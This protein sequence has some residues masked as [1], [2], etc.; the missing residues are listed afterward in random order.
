[1]LGIRPDRLQRRAP[2]HGVAP[3]QHPGKVAIVGR[4][5]RSVV[6]RAEHGQVVVGK[7]VRRRRR[8]HRDVRAADEV[9]APDPGT[10]RQSLAPTAR[11]T[12]SSSSI[13]PTRS[14][15]VAAMPG[16]QRL[17]LAAPAF[18]EQ[19]DPAGERPPEAR[20]RSRRVLSVQ[21]LQMTVMCDVEHGRRER[22]SCT[23]R[24]QSLEQGRPVV[25][26]NRTSSR[27]RPAM[28]ESSSV[29]PRYRGPMAS[30]LAQTACRDEG[31]CKSL[32]LLSA[33]VTGMWLSLG[34]LALLLSGACRQG[35]PVVDLGPKPPQRARHHYWH[36][37]RPRRHVA[38]RRPHSG[39][40]RD[41][42]PAQR[43]SVQTSANGGFTIQVP[44][45][46]YRIEL[47][48]Q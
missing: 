6:N 36:R 26:G 20:A 30:F 38:S 7:P 9:Q 14:P 17:R 3:L 13:M 48:L 28:A 45:G 42:R 19:R 11:S 4:A 33:W 21:A 15:D 41:R 12:S 35:V 25:G 39:D 8:P 2:H 40:R 24:M 10:R 47:P 27:R 1:M 43:H 31:T 22:R 37:A 23:E 44:A 5:L 18:D 32:P 34:I 46:K 16:V 29:Q